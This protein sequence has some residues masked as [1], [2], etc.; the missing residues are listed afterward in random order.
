[1]PLFATGRPVLPVSSALQGHGIRVDCSKCEI[2]RGMQWRHRASSTHAMKGAGSETPLAPIRLTVRRLMRL[3]KRE[4]VGNRHE[5]C[6]RN[7]DRGVGLRSGPNPDP[8]HRS[9]RELAASFRLDSRPAFLRLP[10]GVD[11]QGTEWMGENVVCPYPLVARRD[12]RACICSARITVK[13]DQY[14]G[15]DDLWEPQP[16][17]A[18]RTL[19][20][21]RVGTLHRRWRCCTTTRIAMLA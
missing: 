2:R 19:G 8:A 11:A 6:G 21:G 12:H 5:C 15:A 14:Q 16:R 1:M 17:G 3:V 10:D 18:D 13:R 4:E 9:D 20:G 7:C